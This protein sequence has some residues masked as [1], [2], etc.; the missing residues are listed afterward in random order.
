MRYDLE[1]SASLLS[2]TPATL[3]ALL[4]GLPDPWTA[5][6]E[7]DATWSPFEIVGHLIYGER[8]DWIPRARVILEH[9]E[10]QPFQPFDRAGHLREI[11]GKSLGRLLDDFARAR[12]ES[13]AALRAFRLQPADLER[14]G[15]HPAFG[16][17]TLSQ[18]LAAWPLH[19]LTHLHQI[20]RVLAHQYREAVGPFADYLGVLRCQ[21]HSS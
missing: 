6:R 9:G 4:G 7:G 1:L 10:S 13:L 19:D 2:R 12:A 14:R 18:H 11:Q 8:T 20:S 21:G 3:S 15:R 16:P 17:V 5:A